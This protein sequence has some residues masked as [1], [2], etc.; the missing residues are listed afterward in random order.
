MDAPVRVAVDAMGGDHAPS[1]ILS[2]AIA[3]ARS[4]VL[5]IVLVGSLADCR[6]HLPSTLPPGVRFV[7]VGPAPDADG[8]RQRSPSVDAACAL[9]RDFAAD[10]VVSAGS[11]GCV[12]TSAA[13]NLRRAPGVARPAL[14]VTLPGTRP[15]V[16]LDAGATPEATAEI[17]VQYAVLGSCYAQARFGIPEPT[18]GLLNIG[19]EPGKGNAVARAAHDALQTAPV[20]FHG[21]VEGGD[22]ISGVVDVIV[23]DGFTG[24]VVL[25]TLEATLSLGPQ[26]QHA[27]VDSAACLVGMDRTVLIAHGAVRATG[28]TVAC[29]MAERIVRH[30]VTQEISQRLADRAGR[31]SAGRD[32]FFDVRD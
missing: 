15:T 12:V 20:R 25:K 21:N 14:A 1:E 3:A 30:D 7:D 8:S 24:N 22:L 23:T 28:I 27:D 29:Q 19:T 13:V 18:V 32:G 16:L 5:E 26:T 11:T 6:A 31:P 10:A 17:L 4:G 2:G 9:V